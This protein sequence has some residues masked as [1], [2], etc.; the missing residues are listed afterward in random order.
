VAELRGREHRVGRVEREAEHADP[1]VATTASRSRAFRTSGAA[2]ILTRM[3]GR[4]TDWL[5]QAESDLAHARHAL[6]DGDYDWACFAAQQSAEK[7][8]KAAHAA[9]GQEAWGHVVTELLDGLRP[10]AP[11]VDD[12]LLDRAR[13]LDKHY[14]PTRYPNGLPAGAPA[15]FYTRAEAE[16]AIADAEEIFAVCAGM[17]SRS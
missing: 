7:A 4:A 3:T 12:A 2:G 16:R 10:D 5:R 14:I 17:L 15:D 6:D 1:L 9:V 8:A 13:A 11:A